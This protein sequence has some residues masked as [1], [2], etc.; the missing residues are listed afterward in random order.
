MAHLAGHADEAV[1]AAEADAD[2]PEAG[3]LDDALGDGGVARLKGQDGAGA[4]GGGPVQVV[5]GVGLEAGVA[6]AEAALLEELGNGLGVGLLLLHADGERLDAAHEEEGVVGGEAAA[7]RVDGEEELV[8]DGG[9]VAGDDAGHD[10]VVAGEVLCA[11]LVDDVG[12]EVERV[13][14]HGGEHGVVDDDEGLGVGVVG[15]GGDGGN[16]DNLDERVGR[17]LEQD[18]GRLGGDA[19]GDG[20]DL[21]GVD[22]VDDDARVGGE[23]GQQAVGAAVEVVAGDDLVAGAEDAG[24]DVEGAHARGDGEGAAGAHDLG[25]VALEMGARGVAGAGVVV[26]LLAA[27]GRGLLK[28]GRLVDGRARGAV[29]V[30][31]L[32]VDELGGEGVAAAAV[33]RARGRGRGR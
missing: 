21:C 14:E 19:V 28:G 17:G 5:L 18:H 16:V 33:A 11:R 24:D 27:G 9:V 31:A 30:L 12:A 6:D 29:L 10:V 23:V 1:D 15:A 22:V 13:A 32:G 3:G 8:A 2:G 20:G 4:A 26:L 25:E 7:G